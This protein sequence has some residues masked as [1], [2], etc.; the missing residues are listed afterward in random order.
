MKVTTKATYLKS[1]SGTSN[2]NGEQRTWNRAA[3]LDDELNAISFY[4]DDFSL[5]NGVERTAE[6]ELTL[7]LNQGRNG[8]YC[9]IEDV[10]VL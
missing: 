4:Y 1:E 7:N 2:R 3:F 5:F 6:V 8:F 10:K 9:N